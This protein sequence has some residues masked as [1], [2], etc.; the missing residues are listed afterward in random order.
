MVSGTDR[1]SGHRWL[2]RLAVASLVSQIGIVVSGGGVRLS[3]SGL[4][5]PTFPR[6]TPDSYVNTPEYGVHGVIEFG[7]RLLTFVLVA[8][9]FATLVAAWRRPTR[10][11][12]RPLAL[13]LFLGVPAQAL[14][15]GLTVLTGLDPWVVMLHF[16]CSALLIGVATALVRRVSGDG[17]PPDWPG[18]A[19]LRRLAALILVAAYATAYAGTVVTGSGPHAGD[20]AARRTGLDVETVAQ[21]HVDLVLLL[22]GLSVGLCFAAR[23]VGAPRRVTRAADV[24]LGTELA[25]GAVGAVQYLLGVPAVLVAVHLLG[26]AIVVAAAV[27]AWLATRQPAGG[28]AARLG[29]SAGRAEPRVAAQRGDA[30]KAQSLRPVGSRKAGSVGSTSESPASSATSSAR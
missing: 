28:D 24:L 22:L 1:Q 16:M 14:I 12:V 7:N 20:S 17:T 3:G 18:S 26:A 23:A 25:Q 2:P 6:C 13:V 4:G 21:L 15:G 19:W 29:D 11:G 10:A 5:C 30:M 9:A 8:V 27:D